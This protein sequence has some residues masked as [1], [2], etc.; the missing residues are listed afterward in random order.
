[1]TYVDP[2]G[3]VLSHLDRVQRWTEGETPAPVTIEWDLSNRC[4]LGCQDC[5]FA[6][7][8]TRGPWTAGRR[9]LPMAHDRGG[10]LADTALV[11]RTLTEVAR[12]DH[13]LCGVQGV[14]WTGGG[15][16]TTHP[17]WPEIMKHAAE[18]GLEQ[19]VYTLGGLLTPLSASLMAGYATWVVVSLDAVDAETYALEKRV[20]ESR[21][22]AALDGIRALVGHK[23][24]IG[25]SFLLHEHNWRFAERMVDLGRSLGANY[26]TLR[27]VIR[28]SPTN[29]AKLTDERWWIESS[30]PLLTRLSQMPDV[31]CNPDR[32]RDLL[33]WKDHGYTTCYGIRLNT[34][35]TPDGRM[36]VCPN[37]REYAGASCLGDLRTESFTSIWARHPGRWTDF[38]ECRAM[39]RLHYA[40]QTLDAIHRPRSHTAFI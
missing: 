5:H 29:P 7:T 15:E 23:A 9:D 14:V 32:F 37:R 1:M 2:A 25:V 22:R 19:G 3:K 17:D 16:P 33:N 24:V 4:V 28:T 6:Y 11:T 30:K 36:W 13:G 26:T 31:E 12:M 39:C 10:D 34:T 38:R 20:P 40:N 8:H 18:E 21:Y 35:I 27:P